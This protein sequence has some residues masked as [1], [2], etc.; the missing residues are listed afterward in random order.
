MGGAEARSLVEHRPTPDELLRRVQAE[1][2]RQRR[3][4]L[5]V[6]L[7]YAPRV[8]KSYRMLDEG[9]RRKMRGADVVVAATQ[10]QPDPEIAHLLAAL[11]SVPL[12]SVN[13][14]GQTYG[15]LDIPAIFRRQPGVCL[16]DELAYDNPPGSRNPHRWQDVEEL[17]ENGI[18]V[19]TA[20]NLQHIAEQQDAVQRI[21]GRR[22]VQSVPQAFLH[23]ADEIEL[24]DAALDSL[25]ARGA[26]PEELR[27]F[28]E[29]RE[30]ALL[31]A[32]DV[33]DRQLRVYLDAHG[34]RQAWG[35]HERIL[36]CLTPRSNARRMLESGRRN[37]QRFHGELLAAWVRQPGADAR[38]RAAI[39]EHL[40]LAQSLG[41]EVH[42]LE[43]ADFIAAILDFARS[44]G[45]TQIFL[46]HS[47]QEGWL[48][49]LRGSPLD[50]LIEGATDMDVRI[51][52]HGEQP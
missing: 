11:E 50:R 39:E 23:E 52:P 20:V 16:V 44:R 33:V 26:G 2:R 42:I 8:G 3:G 51:F 10:S 43:G 30:L 35:A 45:V 1:E 31:L 36:V 37:A 29:L 21:T 12:V 9:R 17:L 38:A 15:V 7:G 13:H 49:R 28:A 41:A 18:R 46:G 22:A 19:I 14:G 34:I 25:A 32:A 40:Q 48:S 5:K 6:F 27:R 47:L 24:V 4:R